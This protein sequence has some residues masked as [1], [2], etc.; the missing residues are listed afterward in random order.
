M[1]DNFLATELD[2]LLFPFNYMCTYHGEHV[3]AQGQPV[4]VGSFRPPGGS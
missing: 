3:K 4:G 1:K 2:P